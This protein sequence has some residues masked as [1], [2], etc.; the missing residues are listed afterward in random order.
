MQ[1]YLGMVFPF[2]FNYIPQG[3]YANCNGAL[4]P[5]NSNQ[6]L[7]ALLGVNFGGN[8]TTN[9]GLP[10]LQG[11][12]PV[13]QGVGTGIG[14]YTIGEIGGA[15]KV[16]MLASNMPAHTH[17]PTFHAVS[18]DESTPDASSN[19]AYFGGGG[20]NIYA[21]SMVAGNALGSPIAT[22]AVG[23]SQPI[24]TMN[25]YVAMM[26]CIATSGIFPSRN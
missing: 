17:V 4:L 2:A 20:A 26:Y 9:F 10:N 3:G 22:S 1:P 16:T 25:G 14:T 7:F 8:G 5:I 13:G 21:S 6:A 11:R 23:G 15:E 18:N 19:T 24:P 12:F